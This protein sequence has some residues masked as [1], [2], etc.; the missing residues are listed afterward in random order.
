MLNS[1]QDIYT[2]LIRLREYY[3]RGLERVSG[4]E[5]RERGFRML[6]SGLDIAIVP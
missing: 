1:K 5:D 3:E 6:S 4:P 2:I